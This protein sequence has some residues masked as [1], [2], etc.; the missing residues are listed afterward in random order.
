[1][2]V[3]FRHRILATPRLQ[4]ARL[5]L[6]ACADRAKLFPSTPPAD[7][8]GSSL[9]AGILLL[10]RDA[11]AGFLPAG[12]AVTQPGPVTGRVTPPMLDA[13]ARS[14]LPRTICPDLGIGRPWGSREL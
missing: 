7:S 11:A 4:R 1:M 6:Q 13:L 12:N 9:S 3:P 10:T 14:T 8:E 5:E 2:T